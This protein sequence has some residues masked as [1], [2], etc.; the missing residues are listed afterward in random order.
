VIGNLPIS[1]KFDF[2]SD[3][4]RGPDSLT[5]TLRATLGESQPLAL[6]VLSAMVP[7][8]G[9]GRDSSTTIREG[10]LQASLGSGVWRLQRL[11]LT[12]PSLD[13]FAEGT[14]TTGGGLNLAVNAGS[15]TRPGQTLIQRFTPLSAAAAA[16]PRRPL[17]RVILADLA[18]SIGSYVVYME[19][20][21]TIDSPVIRVNPLRTLT[22]GAARFFLL[23]F[24]T[25]VPLP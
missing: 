19:V 14:V 7:Y 8:L 3:Q 16:T 12:G 22:E 21:G 10:E 2:G 11:S 17:D 23:R 4:Y 9:Y 15:R 25:P 13:L 20:G 6:P 1:G 18:S 5:G 24:F